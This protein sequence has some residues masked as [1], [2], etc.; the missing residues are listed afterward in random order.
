MP[1]RERNENPT[2]DNPSLLFSTQEND[3]DER[4]A[5]PAVIFLRDL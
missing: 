2:K 3:K 1:A 5:I 4:D